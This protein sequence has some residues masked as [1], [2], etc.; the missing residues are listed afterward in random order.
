VRATGVARWTGPSRGA[1]AGPAAPSRVGACGTGPTALG[2]AR[3]YLSCGN[4]LPG[5]ATARA[6][7]RC[8]VPSGND[9]GLFVFHGSEYYEYLIANYSIK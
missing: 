9:R 4:D 3:C 5:P 2:L 7:R 1:W 6:H 8:P